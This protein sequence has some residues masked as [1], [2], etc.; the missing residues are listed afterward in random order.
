MKLAWPEQL[1]G[2]TGAPDSY[3]DENCI[4]YQVFAI[5]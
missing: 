5:F 2:H 3:R 4:G 1:I